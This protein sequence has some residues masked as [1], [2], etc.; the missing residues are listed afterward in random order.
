MG[1]V[2]RLRALSIGVFLA[3]GACTGVADWQAVGPPGGPPP[4]DGGP[5]VTRL[6]RWEAAGEG[7]P[8]GA[9]VRHLAHHDGQLFAIVDVAGA[10]ALH[11]RPLVG[12]AWRASEPEGRSPT[13]SFRAIAVFDRTL[14]LTTADANAGTGGVYTLRFADE[15]WRRVETAPALPLSALLRRNG[16]LLVAASGALATA[17]LYS[18]RDGGV[19]WARRAEAQGAAA[20]LAHPVRALVASPAAQRMFAVGDAGAGFA[21][22]FSSDDGG[23][24]W[25]PAALKGEVIDLAA[26]DAFVLAST[27]E[28]GEQRSDNYGSTFHPMTMGQGKAATAFFVSGARALAATSGG[29]LVSDDGGATWRNASEGL[30]SPVELSRVYIAGRTA[31]AAG[32]S[33]VFIARLQ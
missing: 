14:Y 2:R 20:F 4:P 30:P 31:V 11:V 26:S 17:G 8:S 32:P 27:T 7:L 22:L 5:E 33:G 18:S 19:T 29:V 15:P 10:S 25:G 3:F 28:V 12:G 13:E 21:G 24:T 9:A 23:A 16:E 1:M 6:G